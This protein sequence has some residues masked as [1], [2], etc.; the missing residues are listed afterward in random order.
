MVTKEEVQTAFDRLS[1]MRI[2]R[3]GTASQGLFLQPIDLGT[4]LHATTIVYRGDNYIPQSVRD[5]VRF[6]L[7]TPYRQIHTWLTVDEELFQISLHHI[8]NLSNIG[9]EELQEIASEFEDAA[10]KW[11]EI[12]EERDRQDLVHI[13]NRK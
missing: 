2:A 5:A 10:F 4:K 9:L 12:F 1:T 8:G 6:H 7:E 3:I 11:R 13:H